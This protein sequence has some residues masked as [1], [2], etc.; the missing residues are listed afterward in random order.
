MLN[1]LQQNG[2]VNTFLTAQITKIYTH[3]NLGSTTIPKGSTPQA[4]G[5][6]NGGPLTDNAEGEDI[7]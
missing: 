2:V 6:G 7:V 5:G 1:V 4:D 3:L